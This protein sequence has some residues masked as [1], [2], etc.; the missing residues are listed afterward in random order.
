MV[1]LVEYF[2]GGLA[3]AA[4]GYGD[5]L[6]AWNLTADGADA[7]LARLCAVL[8]EAGLTPD[9][10]ARATAYV[11]AADA[12]EAVYAAWD[13]LFA[14]PGNRPAFKVLLAQLP[15]GVGVRVDALAL[16]GGTRR[17]IDIQRVP[18][19]DP[20]VTIGNWMVTSRVHGTDPRTGHVPDDLHAETRQAMENVRTLLGLAGRS[21]DDLTQLVVFVRKT[22]D[23]QYVRA[24]VGQVFPGFDASR[25]PVLTNFV[26]PSM[27]LMVEAIATS[28]AHALREIWV[29]PESCA[30][31][32]AVWL[33]QLLFSGA[34]YGAG[35]DFE[36]QLRDALQRM[37]ATLDAA[38]LSLKD[39]GQVAV[40]MRDLEWKPVFNTVWSDLFPDAK[41]RPP[42]K[43]VPLDGGDRGHLVQLQVF[44]LAEGGRR[45]LEIP[46]MAHGDPMSMGAR[47]GNL[48]FSSRVVGTDT[49]TGITPADDDAQARLAFDNVR[50]LLKQAGSD[51]SG[52]TQVNAFINDD[53]GRAATLRAWRRLFPDGSDGPRLQFLNARLP[54]SSVVRLE[55]LAAC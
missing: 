47:L 12:R 7:G 43:Y 44:A 22:D 45:V 26:A 33:G 53:A 17:R 36:S 55:V 40:Y 42:H 11:G 27:R 4:I 28:D 41:D 35:D 37:R 20:T 34:L 18:A 50:T 29:Q 38:G 9:N 15:Q 51:L 13:R 32:D 1:G 46:G 24:A 23:A 10:V 8:A 5:A 39:V 48:V 21:A 6:L 14:D 25:M 52:M 54:G 2:A 30:L 49:S 31:P 19:R 16:A 3:P